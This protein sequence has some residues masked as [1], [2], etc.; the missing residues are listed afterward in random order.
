[1]T[2]DAESIKVLEGL[3]AVRKRPGMYIG[4]TGNYGLHHIAYEVIDNSV[5][6]AMG[7]FCTEI[8]VTIHMDNSLTVVDDGRGIPVNQHPTEK[9]PAAEVVMTKLHAGG[10]FDS[11]S[12]KVSGGLH[13]VGV[14]VTNALSEWLELEIRRDGAVYQ[15]RYEVG[16]PAGT[17]RKI[18]KTRKR[19]TKITFRPSREI[20]EVTEFSFDILAKR[21]RE[22]SFLNKGL[23][24][25]LTDERSG[26]EKLFHYKGGIASFV[27]H[28]NRN[29]TPLHKKP[30]YLE[31]EREGVS[32]EIA[33]QY[34]DSY[35]ENLY[36]F[37]NN[38]NTIDGGTHL[39]G[40]KSALTRTLN[41]YAAQN[42]LL[43]KVKKSL[44]GDDVREGLTAV[45]SVKVPD[46]QFEGQ[47]KTKLGNSN[48]KGIVEAAVNES[49]GTFC[50]E[51]PSVAK[52]II[53]KSVNALMARDAARK[54]R[55]L[56]RR[57]GLLEVGTLPGKLA[58]CSERDPARSEIFIVEGDS[59]GGSAKMGRDRRTQAILPLKGKILNVEKA[60]YDKMLSSQEIKT[61]ITALGTGIGKDDFDI[62]KAR[63][64]KIIIMTDADVDGAHISTLLMTFFYRQM[65]PLIEKGYLFLAQPPLYKVKRGKSEKYIPDE[66]AMEDYLL[67]AGIN[68]LKMNKED[69]SRT[70]TSQK[71]VEILKTLIRYEKILE[72]FEK[73]RISANLLRAMVLEGGVNEETLKNRK[74]LEAGMKRVKKYLKIFFPELS[75]ADFTVETDEEYGCYKVLFRIRQ[76]S[77]LREGEIGQELL[78]SPEYKELLQLNPRA[79]GLGMPPYRVQDNGESAE[80]TTSRKLVNFILDR[81]KKGLTIQRYKGL[82]EMN[83]EQLW[84]TTMSV[85]KRRLLQVKIEDAVEADE[86]FTV[87]MGDQVEPRRAFILD[88]ALKV[89]NLDI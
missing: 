69:G 35:S 83:P 44:S 1:M 12:Y 41:A 89:K 42:N 33:M 72:R 19:G 23:K 32:I 52:K 74:T 50:E 88:N 8:Q 87:L 6:E 51:N 3:E 79:Q 9:I 43:K 56:T 68:G 39:I 15:Q 77:G 26:E 2:Y 82:G 4:D 30:I 85:E 14:S 31:L 38:I 73:K 65:L 59:A 18:G 27:E 34:N 60:R 11:A 10:K 70:F 55:D 78:E 40:F 53:M 81:G 13:G 75:S 28:L 57:K 67:N 49:L 5:D 37:A 20:F 24:I 54:A 47:T 76:N 66:A 17:L 84:E 16:V 64:G 21:L 25:S 7:G 46:P 62:T 86:I 45:I 71:G 29:K 36:S 61:L 63:Y 48:V 58:D 80:F 22:L